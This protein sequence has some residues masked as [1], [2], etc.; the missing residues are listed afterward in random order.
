MEETEQLDGV[1]GQIVE[2]MLHSPG[3]VTAKRRSCTTIRLT[4]AD[5]G[6]GE[7]LIDEVVSTVKLD[8]LT[9]PLIGIGGE[10]VDRGGERHSASVVGDVYIDCGEV[11]LRGD[12]IGPDVHEG[13]LLSE[14][15]PLLSPE[16]HVG[17]VEK[18]VQGLIVDAQLRG[19]VCHL[20]DAIAQFNEIHSLLPTV[21]AS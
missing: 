21:C 7:D 8:D 20:L 16:R 10:R 13:S 19:I 18:Q 11:G 12:D 2:A 15:P 4:K 6:G 14:L 3:R 9:F 5:R 17:V 1:S